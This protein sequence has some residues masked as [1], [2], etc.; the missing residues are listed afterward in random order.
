MWTKKQRYN[1]QTLSQ[2]LEKANFIKLMQIIKE[3]NFVCSGTILIFKPKFIYG[4]V[5]DLQEQVALNLMQFFF[6]FFI[7]SFLC[8]NQ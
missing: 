2:S 4:H 7:L 6:S 8:V 1:Q 5:C 3:T